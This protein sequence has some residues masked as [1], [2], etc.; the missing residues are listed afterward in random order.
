MLT[1]ASISAMILPAPTPAVP[2]A[3]QRRGRPTKAEAAYTKQQ[4]EDARALNT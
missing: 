3:R 2:I 4:E 1:V